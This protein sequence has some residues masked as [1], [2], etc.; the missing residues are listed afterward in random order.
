MNWKQYINGANFFLGDKNVK[1]IEE[2]RNT[3]FERTDKEVDAPEC[4]LISKWSGAEELSIGITKEVTTVTK[5]DIELLEKHMD[6][7][8]QERI[9]PKPIQ[10]ESIQD[11]FGATSVEV[12]EVL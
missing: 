12:W 5:E 1:K 11:Y 6:E 10:R 4:N 7:M 2:S 8:I 9:A 3:R